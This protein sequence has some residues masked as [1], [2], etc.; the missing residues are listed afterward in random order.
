MS[1]I[2]FKGESATSEML[3]RRACVCIHD[4]KGEE[5][6][7]TTKSEGESSENQCNS[8]GGTGGIW[9]RGPYVSEG[10]RCEKAMY[11]QRLRR[12]T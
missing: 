12:F 3:S 11:E 8:S 6:V 7:I 2:F 9:D 4:E 5:E 1:P 10:Q